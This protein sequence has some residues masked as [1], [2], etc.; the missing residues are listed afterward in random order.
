MGD[1]VHRNHVGWG[2]AGPYVNQTGRNDIV[3]AK[4]SYD[5]QYVYFYVRTRDPLS[6]SH[7]IRTGC[8]CSSTR[9]PRQ[10]TGWLGYDVV[11]NATNDSET[12]TTLQ[13]NVGARYEWHQPIVVRAPRVGQ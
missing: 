7:A 1:P 8:C 11:V 9:T 4:V 13:Q 5:Q 12:T 3:V 6:P 10:S 2:D